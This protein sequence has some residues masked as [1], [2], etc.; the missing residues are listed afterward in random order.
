MSAGV[1]STAVPLRLLL[2]EDEP[3]QMLLT[4]RM[5]RRGGYEVDTATDGA[6]ALVKLATGRFQFLVT[7]WEMPGMDGPT[8]CRMARANPAAR[9]SVHPAADGPDRHAQ[10]GDRSGLRCR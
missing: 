4:Q 8:L 6:T 2:V 1:A 9:I 10:C 5:L 7:D 3:T